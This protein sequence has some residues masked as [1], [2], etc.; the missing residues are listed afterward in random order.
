MESSEKEDSSSGRVLPGREKIALAAVLSAGM[1]L[2]LVLV[3]NKRYD[4]DE[5]QHLHVAWGWTQGLL[6]YRDIFDNHTPLFHMLTAPAVAWLGETPDILFFMRLAMI[7]FVAIAMLSLLAL[8]GRLFDRRTGLW[9]VAVG[10]LLPGFFSKSIEYRSDAPWTAFWLLGLALL[11]AGIGAGTAS[12]R[13]WSSGW[14]FASGLAFGA[15]ISVSMKTIVMI[16]AILGGAILVRLLLPDRSTGGSGSSLRERL[17][18]ALSFAGG[19]LAIPSAIVLFFVSKGAFGDLLEGTIFHNTVPG[20]GRWNAGFQL[21]LLVPFLLLLA[22]GIRRGFA[23]S[24]AGRYHRHVP[25]LAAIAGLYFILFFCVWPLVTPQDWMPLLP[26]VALLAIGFIRPRMRWLVAFAGIEVAVVCF[27]PA[28]L[29]DQT[30]HTERVLQDVLALTDPGDFVMDKKGESVFRRRPF[31]YALERVTRERMSRGDIEDTIPEDVQRTATCVV[32]GKPSDYPER[33]S[34]FLEKNFLVVGD[35]SVAGMMLADRAE[36]AR[37]IEFEV[38]IP[39]DYEV[40]SDNGAV[41]GTLDGAIAAG[42]VHLG[43]GPHSFLPAHDT[44]RIALVYARAAESG[45]SPFGKGHRK[46]AGAAPGAA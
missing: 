39:A 3:F 5:P 38:A 42:P 36:A 9:A 29:E 22:W 37:P 30:R 11:A 28:F 7:P 20:L 10:A 45:F 16:S 13:R 26:L 33:A 43:A 1:L 41:P 2:R 27:S 31:Y 40:R 46:S 18:P 15:A 4:T 25:L 35:V 17:G 23:G 14:L 19:F 24:R 34:R 44:G 12:A 8:G 21:L 32:L 6:P